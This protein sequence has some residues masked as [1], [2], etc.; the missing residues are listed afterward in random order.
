MSR[1]EAMA[2]A[3]YAVDKTDAQPAWERASEAMRS[4]FYG[5]ADAALE[6]LGEAPTP[7]PVLPLPWKPQGARL[8]RRTDREVVERQE[9]SRK[10]KRSVDREW[11]AENGLIGLGEVKA[12]TGFGHTWIYE[13]TRRRQFPAAIRVG[14]FTFWR[15]AEVLEWVR[16]RKAHLL[17]LMAGVDECD[18]GPHD[19]G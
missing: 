11:A 4:H 10:K 18:K 6:A 12:L 2:A 3:M 17:A 5:Y 13:K 1:R 8:R 16:Q 19:A 7:D 15:E 14:L 9:A